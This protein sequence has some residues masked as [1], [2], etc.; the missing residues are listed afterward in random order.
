[1]IAGARSPGAA[2]LGKTAGVVAL[3]LLLAGPP[4]VRWLGG[5]GGEDQL[6]L[7]V[8]SPHSEQIEYE[9][10]RGFSQW[11]ERHFGQAVR[12]DWRNV[13]GSSQIARFLNSRFDAAFDRYWRQKH[14]RSL[15]VLDW[16][17]PEKIDDPKL[18]AQA[19][20]IRT[21]LLA[22][23]AGI[24]IDVYFG[25]GMYDHDRAK[26]RGQ[27][28]PVQLDASIAEQIPASLGGDRLYDPNGYWW[29]AALS[30]F[31]IL[32]N[33]QVLGQLGVDP[34]QRWADL[35]DGRLFRQIALAD[36]RFSGSAMKGFEMILQAAMQRQL[37]KAG[38]DRAEALQ[39]GWMEGLALIRR[40]GA[41]ARYF[42]DSSSKIAH[43]L[44]AGNAAAGM[45][46]DFYG[47]SQIQYCG[48]DVLGY[49][50]P[51]GGT[52]FSPD[53]I[54][55]LRGAPHRQLAQRFVHYVLS[56]DGQMLWDLPV[57]FVDPKT[58]RR[59]PIRYAL[60]RL[61]INEEVY[62]LYG[63]D[64]L[65]G[66]NPYGTGR[67]L[68]HYDS[69]LTGRLFN[70]LRALIGAM[71]VDEH[72]LLQR[73]WRTILDADRARRKQLSAA[74]DA[75]PISYQEAMETA[76]QLSD[77]IRAYQLRRR[78]RGFFRGRYRSVVAG[79]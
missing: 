36:P 32:Y 71:C 57:G 46:I 70:L 42:T 58:G 26:A 30:S 28:V 72:D 25:G 48:S 15:P 54:S 23:E 7:V 52:S 59:G 29:G 20:R 63:E 44:S 8:I 19:Q 39:R 16:A 60:R 69:K 41:N 66:L 76:G 37:A 35:A 79:E 6:T 64:L 27:T 61:P 9:F 1:M 17:R 34:P 4:T 51:T 33:R 40:L 11:H 53:P 77:P 74:F 67:Q 24:G 43:E 2:R 18:R 68:L 5:L 73:A 22:S 50:N 62:E 47:A 49:V 65:E 45:V 56:V 31:G 14:G 13:G 75:L 10:G 78:W 55:V 12:V 21:E 38:T 3:V